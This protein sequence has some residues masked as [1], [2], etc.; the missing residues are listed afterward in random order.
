MVSQYAF[1]TLVV[2]TQHATCGKSHHIFQ[3]MVT[4]ILLFD[5]TLKS[6]NRKNYLSFS[7]IIISLNIIVN[8][9][10]LGLELVLG[11]NRHFTNGSLAL[12]SG[13]LSVPHLRHN[14]AYV[15]K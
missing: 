6:F 11:Q 7:C 1:S 15:L 13:N 5:K 12:G 2:G 8:L 3:A 9:I 10:S 14:V 4:T